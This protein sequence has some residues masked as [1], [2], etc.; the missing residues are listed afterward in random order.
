MLHV[1]TVSGL[2]LLALTL[3]GS[4]QACQPAAPSAPPP[5]VTIVPDS[6]RYTLPYDL[7]QPVREVALPAGLEE[8]SGL[9]YAGDSSLLLIEDE[10]GRLY[11]YDLRGDS[12]IGRYPF[13]P[14]RDYEGIEL[15]GDT[16]WVLHS[17]GDLYRVA[18]YA[19]GAGT[20]EKIKTGLPEDLDYEGLAWGPAGQLWVLAK[21]PPQRGDKKVKEIR[22]AFAWPGDPTK[23]AL[24]IDMREVAAF[25][26]AYPPP[27]EVIDF[28]PDKSGSFKPSGLAIHPQ[29]GHI[30]VI[31]SA[32]ALLVVLNPRQQVVAVHPLPRERFPQPEGLAFG[33]DGTLYIG[34]EGREGPGRLLA[35]APLP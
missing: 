32:G 14:D 1:S 30:Y 29:D 10:H 26:Q 5:P 35:F 22:V 24:R 19:S 8:A 18:D 20:G 25:L 12:L 2:T 4:L 6:G 11:H 34:S 33:P 7:E 31:A 23:A 16:A 28:D 9:V 3:A 13:G 17:S 27:G 15:R 21:E